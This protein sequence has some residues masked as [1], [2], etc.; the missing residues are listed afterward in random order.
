MR[1]RER[2]DMKVYSTVKL[3]FFTTILELQYDFGKQKEREKIVC[4]GE[5]RNKNQYF[6][7]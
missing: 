4:E 2:E 1:E 6:F 7:D 5:R 3:L